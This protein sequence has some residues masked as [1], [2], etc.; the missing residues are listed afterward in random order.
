MQLVSSIYSNVSSTTWRERGGEALP[1]SL[2]KLFPSVIADYLLSVVCPLFSLLFPLLLSKVNVSL[3]FHPELKQLA[4]CAYS[5]FELWPN[6]LA[7]VLSLFS[8]TSCLSPLVLISLNTCVDQINK[9]EQNKFWQAIEVVLMCISAP[10]LE[11]ALL[12]NKCKV[13]LFKVVKML[14]VLPLPSLIPLSLL[15]LPSLPPLDLRLFTGPE[16]FIRESQHYNLR[17]DLF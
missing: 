6:I 9:K 12:H 14:K 8:G 7:A 5:I 17:K 13:E 2:E 16:I 3:Q 11:T 10:Q 1:Q 4:S 15:S